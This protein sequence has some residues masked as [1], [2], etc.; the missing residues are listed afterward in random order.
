MSVVPK[1]AKK[2]STRPSGKSASKAEG[3]KAA[4]TTRVPEAVLASLDR[5]A[6]AQ[7]TTVAGLQRQLLEDFVAAHEQ[8]RPAP[9]LTLAD[10]DEKLDRLLQAVAKEQVDLVKLRYETNQLGSLVQQLRLM[11]NP[12]AGARPGAQQTR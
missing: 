6:K 1:T 7:S 5:L 8:T 12:A 3:D 9:V 2:R 11:L 10:L 4:V